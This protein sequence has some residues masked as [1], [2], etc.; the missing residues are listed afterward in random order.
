MSERMSEGTSEG[1]SGSTSEAVVRDVPERSRFEIHVDGQ[2]AGLAAYRTRPGEVTI[3]HTEI[4]PA[5][6]GRGLG[7]AL[8]RAALDDLRARGVAVL[9]VCPFFRS[10]I[11]RHPDYADLVPA[12]QHG[13]LGLPA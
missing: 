9:P 10:W 4:D 6:E 12:A 3:Y 5:F 13:R 1:T 2:R 7:S 8:A 11:Q